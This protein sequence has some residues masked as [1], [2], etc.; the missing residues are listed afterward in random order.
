MSFA[1]S[2]A[3]R[4]RLRREEEF[5]SAPSAATFLYR[6]WKKRIALFSFSIYTACRKQAVCFDWPL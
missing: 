2:T 6:Q 3:L 4:A 5:S 1:R